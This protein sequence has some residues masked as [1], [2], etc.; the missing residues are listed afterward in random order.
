MNEKIKLHPISENEYAIWMVQSKDQYREENVKNGLTVVEAQKKTDDDFQRL[1][2]QGLKSKDNYIYAIKV[3]ARWVGTVWFGVRGAENN[4]K[5]FIFDLVLDE[6]ARGKGHGK[7]AMLLI[8]DEV[9][10][11]GLKHIGLHVFGHN[12][13][14]RNLYQSLGYEIMNLILEKTLT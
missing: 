6:N 1:L 5:A 3:E 7:Q 8:E 4:R 12:K 11:I 9:K 13:I 2:P 10:K 14:A